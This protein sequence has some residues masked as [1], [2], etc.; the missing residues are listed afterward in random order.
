MNAAEMQARIDQLV[1]ENQA[2]GAQVDA[3]RD[4]RRAINAEIK[5]LAGTLKLAA[6]MEASPEIRHAIAPGATVEVSAAEV[7]QAMAGAV[8]H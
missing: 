3:L 1:A 2:L 7:L 4:K 8:K 6:V 5:K